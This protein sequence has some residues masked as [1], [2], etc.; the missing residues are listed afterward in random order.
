MLKQQYVEIG[1]FV[2][3]GNPPVQQHS[4]E[5]KSLVCNSFSDVM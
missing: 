4:R 5:Y 2:W 3:F 1:S